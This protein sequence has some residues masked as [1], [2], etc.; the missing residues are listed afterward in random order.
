MYNGRNFMAFL[1][2]LNLI[3][4]GTGLCLGIICF[5][6]DRGLLGRYESRGSLSQDLFNQLYLIMLKSMALFYFTGLFMIAFSTV[7]FGIY[8]VPYI[9]ALPVEISVGLLS[10]IA[11]LAV[12][13][14]LALPAAFK[15]PIIDDSVYLTAMPANEPA[16]YE[17]ADEM[18]DHFNMPPIADIRITPGAEIQITEDVYC[19]DDVFDGGSKRIEIGLA[20]LQFLTASDF[21]MLLARQFSSFRN[22][23]QSLGVIVNKLNR[24]LKLMTDNL[25]AAGFIYTI[26]PVFLFA[27]SAQSLVS[28][29]TRDCSLLA[30]I[31]ADELAAEFG[32]SNRLKNA[33]ARYNVETENYRGIIEAAGLRRGP[34]D[35][36]LENIYDVMR[37]AYREPNN[38]ISEMAG[39]LF[40][41]DDRKQEGI[42][43]S[44]K[45]RLKRL[46]ETPEN[47]FET[48]HPAYDYLSDWLGTKNKMMEV[49][50]KETYY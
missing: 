12:G 30:E 36:G 47:E 11:A 33:L 32:G 19:I 39:Y 25:L 4:L 31:N 21:K 9:L 29:I 14:I 37:N 48:G 24:R 23:D 35:E 15:R 50:N 38:I 41:A 26:N 43:R 22:G 7:I 40:S 6:L 3:I 13:G 5:Y 46:P 1:L 8:S 45:L 20:S 49:L 16:L 27:Y 10:V 18:V 2:K 42:K 17:L 44:L 28:H 34:G